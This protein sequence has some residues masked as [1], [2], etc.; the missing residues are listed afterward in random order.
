MQTWLNYLRSQRDD[1]HVLL[2]AKLAGHGSKDARSYRLT[3]FIDEYSR[4]RIEADVA[5]I[6]AAGFLAHSHDHAAH[7]LAFFDI[8]I[9]RSF[10]HCRRY[11]ISETSP[12]PE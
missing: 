12:D 2:L 9:R 10:F 5:A 11:Y 3:H 7:D 6:F 1:L 8:R 4:V